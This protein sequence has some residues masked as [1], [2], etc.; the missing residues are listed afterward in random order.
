MWLII[1]EVISCGNKNEY[2]V[3]MLILSL[4]VFPQHEQ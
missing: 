3:V 1:A 4:G 2:S